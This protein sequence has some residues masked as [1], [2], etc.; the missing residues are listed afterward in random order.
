MKKSLMTI[1][2]LLLAGTIAVNAGPRMQ[3]F[4]DTAKV[5]DVEPIYETIA[6]S[7][8]EE[9]CWDED[10]SYYEPGR[11]QYTG[12]VLGSV[13]GGTLANQL[14]RGGG[15]GRDAATLAG[16]LLGGAIGHDVS[17]HNK[18]GHHR[19]TTQRH[20]ETRNYTSYEEQLVGYR[21]KYRYR[22]QV[23]TTRTENHPG[24]RIPI[25][26]SVAPIDAF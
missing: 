22:G 8:P 15:K 21:V 16:A 5:L 1:G 23:F 7:Q 9:H 4:Q 17:E 25:R 10:V 6:V 2:T 13:I 14:H 19:T 18:H 20:C 24:R 12:T 11:K 26:V 3:R